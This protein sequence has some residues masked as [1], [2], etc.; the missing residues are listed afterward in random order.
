M[1]G[2]ITQNDLEKLMAI[3]SR[4]GSETDLV[5]KIRMISAA[6]RDIIKAERCTLFVHDRHTGTFWTAYAD[7]ISYIELPD[8]RGIIGKV[9]H[10]KET[11][12]ENDVEHHPEFF[13][14]IDSSSGFRTRSILAM[15]VIGFGQECIGV[16]QL[17]NKHDEEIFTEK[18]VKI[19]QFVLSH[20][21]AF[22]QSMVHEHR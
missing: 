6:I 9:C 7:G 1:S 18:D 22:V 12:V 15:P 21:A 8:N 13:G 14:G 16:V 11:L 2:D 4:L 19:L 17:L 20:F 3:N 10:E 5:N